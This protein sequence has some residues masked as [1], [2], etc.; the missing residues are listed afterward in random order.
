MRSQASSIALVWGKD[1]GR[2]LLEVR[3]A[4]PLHKDAPHESFLSSYHDREEGISFR[5][6]RNYSLEEG[7]VQERS[8]FLKKQDDFDIDQAGATLLATVLIPEDGYPNTTFEHGSLQ[9]VVDA[10]GT[11]QGCRET[12]LV[13]HNGSRPRTTTIQGIAFKWSEQESE[14]AGT[15]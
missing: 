1:V 4:S 10:A 6:P 9:L 5:Y 7:D 11:E 8:F 13:A 12:S 3:H 2:P 15:K 14:T